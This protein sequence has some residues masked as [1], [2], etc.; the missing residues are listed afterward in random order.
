M[1]NLDTSH[2]GFQDRRSL[3][4]ATTVIPN[5]VNCVDHRCRPGNR[6]LYGQNFPKRGLQYCHS[7]SDGMRRPVIVP[8]LRLR[9]RHAGDRAGII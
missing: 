7:I 6:P 4:K 2:R 3:V 5:H 8:A 9:C 1:S